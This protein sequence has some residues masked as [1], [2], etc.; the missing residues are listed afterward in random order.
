VACRTT[1]KDFEGAIVSFKFKLESLLSHRQFVE[2]VLEKEL[3]AAEKRLS[4]E[5]RIENYLKEKQ[6]RF[7]EE[8]KKNL[9][10]PKPVSENR[11]Y[12][13]YIA[14]LSKKIDDQRLKVQTA[15][16]ERRGK[17]IDLLK[18]VKKRK[19]LER[20]KE[21]HADQYHRF[22]LKKEQEASDEIGIQQYNRKT[23]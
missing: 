12:V 1:L 20:L 4:A 17:K 8:L 6:V 15:E 16:F 13:T 5:R 2:N 21:T 3:A 9:Q 19:I 22:Y 10:A 23:G 11:L 14:S 7:A 18:A